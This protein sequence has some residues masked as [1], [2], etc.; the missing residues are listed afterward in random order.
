[1]KNFIGFFI[2]YPVA[3]NVLILAVVIMGY[4]G[5]K[6]MKSSFFPLV[7]SE[8]ITINISYFG[9][10]PNEIEE[11]V[12][13]KIEDN[14]KGLVGI[15]RVTSVSSENAAIIT[16]EILKG[17]DIDGVL[18][19]AKNAVDRVPNFPSEMEPPVVAKVENIQRAIALTLSGEQMDLRTLKSLARSV[20]E[21]LRNINGISQIEMAGF[22]NEEIEIA[23]QDQLLKAYNLSFNQVA[24]AVAQT[25]ILSTGGSIKTQQEE[26][27]IRA[28]NKYYNAI[29]F[30]NII[31]RSDDSGNII[32]LRDVAKV[33]DKWEENP[34]RIYYNG[35]PAIS[36]DVF[37]TNSEDLIANSDKVREYMVDYNERSAN[38]KLNVS[39]DAAITLKQRTE[40]LQE[41]GLIGIGLVL[42]LLSVFLKPRFAFWVAFGLPISF[43]GMFMFASYF[44]VTINVLSLF[45]MIIVIGILVDDGI[46]IAENIYNEFEKGKSPIQAAIDGTIDVLPA[47]ISAIL[48]TII[49]FA[50]F[51]Y[52]DGRVG[53]FFSEVSTVVILTLAVS[54]VEALLILPA[55]LA[56]SKALKKGKGSFVI[57]KYGDAVLRW[58]RDTL[59]A[60][61]FR[62]ILNNRILGLAIPITIFLMTLG[63]MKGG[64]I[65]FT[66]FPAIASDVVQVSL[67]MPQGTNEQITKEIIA[68]IE[69]EVWN[70]NEEL[71]LKQT[72]EKPVIVNCIKKIGP[73]TSVASLT[74][75]LLPGEERDFSAL[76]VSN[77]IRE[78]VGFVPGVEQLNF[79]SNTNFGGSPISIS[80]TGN[81]IQELKAAKEELK[82]KLETLAQLKDV[83]DNDPLG[84]K[85]IKL[86]LKPNAYML[87]F[88]L[89]S[90]MAQVRSGFFG[91]LAQRFQRGRDE[92]RVYVRYDEEGRNSVNDLTDME[93]LAPNGARVPLSE[94]AS[95]EIARGE[96]AINHLDGKREIKVE[97]NLV[98]NKDSAPAI[99][100]NL[101]ASFIPTLLAKYP[102]VSPL[103]EGQN[104]EAQKMISS[105]GKILPIIMLLIYVVIA[106]TF[107][108]YIQPVLLLLMIP[109]SLI[110]VGWG[111]YVHDFPVNI[112]SFLGIIA[113]IGIMVNDGLVLIGKFNSY[114]KDGYSFDKAIYTAG[115]SRFRAIFLTSVTTIAGLTPLIFETSFQAQFLIP[116]AI[117]IAYGIGM[118]TFLTLYLLPVLLYLKNDVQF[119]WSWFYNGVRPKRHEFEGAYQ[120]LKN[121]KEFD[122][123]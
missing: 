1:M 121:L 34:N 52:I 82:E 83:S 26:Y 105:G 32:Y 71:T 93:V 60:P 67:K 76:V 119:Y 50:T 51:Y 111:H 66:F 96:V 65:P 101:K 40:L 3:T 97:A 53:N 16:I 25:N 102:S 14:L 5:M 86:Q 38:V 68:G 90:L 2:K 41:N 7:P 95:Y 84:I 87:G 23:V 12:V 110:G 114:I 78:K 94:I 59:Y 13:L 47:I 27:L 43:M 28:N 118:A 45:G 46:V 9:A 72:G 104:R 21:D 70:A 79:G 30:E 69:E 11:G 42:L 120:E 55:H 115:L 92:V 81:N 57:N 8:L 17:Y 108:S 109:L 49:A 35:A 39:R 54:L 10:A 18:A 22:P 112:L 116:M 48:T 123:E 85:E 15:D 75:N 63:A 64:V 19:D 100:D 20:E 61:S 37:A 6:G 89:E 36:F 77:S 73:G 113:L 74:I 58:L 117:S 29:N 33:S 88:T 4:M 56:H 103:Y 62:F 31:L 122:N 44:G 98:N 24:A 80:L 107:R 91:R 99:L 106:F